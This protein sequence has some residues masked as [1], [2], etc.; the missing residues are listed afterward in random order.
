MA[1]DHWYDLDLNFSACPRENTSNWLATWKS[2]L[3]PIK[4]S[5]QG[6]ILFELWMEVDVMAALVLLSTWKEI[7]KWYL[8]PWGCAK[9]ATQTTAIGTGM[10]SCTPPRFEKFHPPESCGL[11]VLQLWVRFWKGCGL[12]CG[13]L[14]ARFWTVPSA[15]TAVSKALPTVALGTW[16]SPAR[17]KKIEN[18]RCWFLFIKK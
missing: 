18:E 3:R 15:V 7:H 10:K 16:E 17:L 12:S 8:Q 5:T 2:S 13:K 14:R 1:A 4:G 6:K 9:R 11:L